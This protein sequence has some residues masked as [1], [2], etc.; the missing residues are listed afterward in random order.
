[1]NSIHIF[2]YVLIAT[3]FQC[4]GT[5]EI[6]TTS[7]LLNLREET[8]QAFFHSY[9]SYLA[10]GYPYDEVMPISC[11]ARRFDRRCRGDLDDVLGGYMLTLVDSLDTLIVMREMQRFKHALHLLKNITFERDLDVSVFETNI[12][13]VGG[14]LSAHQ[15]AVLLLSADEYD[16]ITLLTHAQNLVDRLLP[17]FHTNTGI[18]IHRV[19]LMN[20]QIPAETTLTCP[21][22]G[23]TFLLE[24][25]LLSRLTGLPVYEQTAFKALKALWERRSVLGLLGAVIDTSSGQWVQTHSGVGAGIDSFY[26]TVLKGHILLGDGR[27]LDWFEESYAAVQKQ[28]LMQASH[29]GAMCMHYCVVP[30][31]FSLLSITSTVTVFPTHS[32][33]AF[34]TDCDC[35]PYAPQGVNREVSME[36]G[37]VQLY[38]NFVSSLQAFWP[39]LQ[40]LAGHVEAA[41]NTFSRLL[42]IWHKYSALPDIYDVK[43]QSVIGYARDY[44]LRPE[45]VRPCTALP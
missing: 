40:T 10:H 28:T 8:R 31:H 38:S 24:M 45:M 27:L 42:S 43:R 3:A 21:A 20:G 25:G 14:L 22:A 30:P 39:A 44:P 33:H 16:G 7:E 29:W 13:V 12:R 4:C 32:F 23:G 9:D 2:I 11:K 5:V 1:M 37:R 36:K 18:P 34:L 35:N 6:L 41:Q 26:E 19:N 15:L 17:A